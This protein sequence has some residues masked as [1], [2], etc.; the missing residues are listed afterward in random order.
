MSERESVTGAEPGKEATPARAAALA[1]IAAHRLL[2]REAQ[3]L[4]DGEKST[5]SSKDRAATL[6]RKQALLGDTCRYLSGAVSFLASV[7]GLQELGVDGQ[8]PQDAAGEPYTALPALEDLDSDLFSTVFEELHKAIGA[9]RKVYVPTCKHPDL[10][11]PEDRAAMAEVVAHLRTGFALLE[12]AHGDEDAEEES[13]GTEALLDE[14]EQICAPLPSQHGE[15][16]DEAVI[17]RVLNDPRLAAKTAK[18]LRLRRQGAA[19]A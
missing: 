10:A 15:M 3:A 19:P 11:F 4:A 16:S 1:L 6:R 17:A 2:G 5:P 9:L 18:A 13:T 7:V 8:S 14:L 12:A